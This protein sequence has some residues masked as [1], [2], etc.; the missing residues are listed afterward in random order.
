M[1]RLLHDHD[2]GFDLNDLHDALQHLEVGVRITLTVEL[3][4]GQCISL[5]WNGADLALNSIP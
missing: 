4:L 5:V 2:S 3:V 1:E